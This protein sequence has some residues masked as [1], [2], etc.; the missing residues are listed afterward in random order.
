MPHPYSDVPEL[1]VLQSG[2]PVVRIPDRLS[3]PFTPRVRALVDTPDFQRLAQIPQLGLTSKVYP[4]ATHTRFEHSLGVFYN[5]C[6]YLWQ[7]GKDP[8]FAEHVDLHQVQVLL[9]AALLHDLGHWPFCHP[10][11]DLQLPG[12][13][14]HEEFAAEF[15]WPESELTEVLITEWGVEPAEV[16]TVMQGTGT[17]TAQRLMQSV[18]SGPID[19]DKL[20]YL[21]RDSLHAGVP[22]G[23]H[24]DRDRLI[25]SLVVNAAG[26]GLA[27]T[28][29]GKTAA[30]LMVFA[31]YVMFS[32]VYWHHAVRSAT[33]ML[34]RCFY[35]VADRLDFPALFASGEPQFIDDLKEACDGTVVQPL[36]ND[37][38]GPRR[39][40][41]KRVLEL[42]SSQQPE[43]Y[44]RL[45][46]RPYDERLQI[47]NRLTRELRARVG[48]GFGP[49]DV[50]IDAPPV[51]K[52]VEFRIEVRSD[53]SGVYRP[54]A[55]VS[56]VIAALAQ[57]Q[58]DE[59]VKRVRVFAVELA[60][61]AISAEA[62]ESALR[63]VLNA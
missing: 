55:E 32:E 21:E 28:S 8:R 40:L 33:C 2:G 4:G 62:C 51:H 44:H 20:D 13:P 57:T 36:I 52:E 9:A 61:E 22:Y 29:K 60:A 25:Q 35:E 53:K 26:D 17:S 45:A 5:G 10:L 6:R 11:E 50:L 48:C 59:Y 3:V 19:I 30:E 14:R 24:F 42:S 56:P 27:I 16:L 12:V 15:L 37:L 31:R 49:T 18:L 43:L 63:T 47:T 46:G 58:F 34:G 23:R 7:L 39:R 1:S 41:Y 54:L 38:F